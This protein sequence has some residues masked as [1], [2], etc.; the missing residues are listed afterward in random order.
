MLLVVR[1]EC[2]VTRSLTRP[3]MLAVLEFATTVATGAPRT[4]DRP[5]RKGRPAALAVSPFPNG[6]AVREGAER[7]GS[8]PA[9]AGLDVL[10]E[11][12]PP[13]FAPSGEAAQGDEPPSYAA[14]SQY[15]EL[16][17]LLMRSAMGDTS[18]SLSVGIFSPVSVLIWIPSTP[19]VSVASFARS[20]W[21]V[22]AERAT[23]KNRNTGTGSC[24]RPSNRRRRGRCPATAHALPCRTWPWR[25]SA[26]APR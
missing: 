11:R 5:P 4:S 14:L 12:S 20:A 23:E 7:R 1:G 25:G 21:L 26:P 19:W 22:D 18:T 13:A 16:K 15:P 6:V 24:G 9:S 8:K 3:T 17:G 2:R 10:E